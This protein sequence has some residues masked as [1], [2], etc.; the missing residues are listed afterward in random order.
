MIFIK[1]SVLILLQKKIVQY[2]NVLSFHVLNWF[3]IVNNGLWLFDISLFKIRMLT[4]IL[5][6]TDD[7]KT[8]TF[9]A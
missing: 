8:I 6:T 3:K 7:A 9:V 4:Q 1:V 2:I 5:H